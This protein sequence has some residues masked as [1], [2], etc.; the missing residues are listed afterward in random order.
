M[1]G[2]GMGIPSKEAAD[3]RSV[4]RRAVFEEFQRQNPDIQVVNAGG[5][6][7]AGPQ[8]ESMFLMSMAGANPPDVFYVNFRQYYNYIDQGFCQPLDSFLDK[9]PTL[10]D[11]VNPI[12]QKVIRSYDGHVYAM[13]FFQV[14]MG[15]YFRRDFFREAGL[16]PSHPPA[17][18]DELLG[19]SK[20]IAESHPGRYG[21]CFAKGAGYHWSNF[22]Y[23]AGGS[24]T[25]IAGDGSTRCVVDSPA[26]K[27]ALDFFRALT[28]QKWN[29]AA[30]KAVGP[31][32]TVTP[33]F[34]QDIRDGKVAMWFDYSGDVVTSMAGNDL[35]P[36]LIG[37]AAMPR[38]PQNDSHEI[39]AGSWAINARISDPARLEACWRFIRFFASEEAA[40]ISTQSFV[41]QGMA[42]FVNPKYLRQFG[43][44]ASLADVDP[45]YVAANQ[46]LFA[47]GH[48]EPYGR[49]VTQ[50]YSVLDTAL[51]R[52]MLEPNTDAHTILAAA[53]Q[54]MNEKL[55]EF[56]PPEVKATR[57]GWAVGIFCVATLG[58]AGFL[59]YNW[60]KQ[61][62]EVRR[63]VHGGRPLP[64]GW[65]G[66]FRAFMMPAVLTLVLWAYVP[67]LRG[68][69]I[70]FQDYRILKGSSWVGLDNFIAVFTQPIFYK[71]LTNSFVYVG[72]SIAI[73]FLIPILLAIA[74]TEIP[75]G[76][77]LFRTLYYL[78]AMTSGLVISFLWRQL[79]DKTEAGLLNQW[80]GPVIG[81][82]NHTFIHDPSKVWPT[83][84]D[85]LGNP[86]LAMFSVVLPGIW[87]A[88]GPGSILYMAALKNIPDERYEA[89]DID[90]ANW[91]QKIRFITFPGIRPL[92][93]INLLGV[94]IGGFKAMENIFVL[95]FGG[96]LYATHT[97]GL[98]VWTNAFMFL[99]FG[100]ATAA[101]WVMG[102]ILVGFTVVQIRSLLSMRFTTAKP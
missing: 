78:P 8:A 30:G 100:Y 67:L 52:A 17:T 29:S 51:D 90:G 75:I 65:Q 16:D 31:A 74:L 80:L 5:L 82:I 10:F 3:P 86:Q 53:Q 39:N 19:Y 71:A 40:R 96:P 72:L 45:T 13:P 27:A 21:F 93:M 37:I 32:A 43:F 99:K 18:W 87:A 59:A 62:A 79:Y 63:L 84:V 57:R 11:S 26:G 54:E 50:V 15:L 81:W 4:A 47:T 24:V 89:A 101:A 97:M 48:P 76:K 12:V 56:T 6:E 36:S 9:S 23:Q 69:V 55:L 46:Q 91:I 58:L 70:A 2:M 38:G 68:L 25:E 1:A 88:A 22:I 95:T 41:E 73:G 77:A 94:F 98:E 28:V 61:R 44:E 66:Y 35:D 33:Q 83:T 7:M 49:N 14:A 85:W 92:M 102:S 60:R 34:R 20:K 42:A 64:R